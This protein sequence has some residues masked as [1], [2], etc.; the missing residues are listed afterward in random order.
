MSDDGGKERCWGFGG[1]WRSELVWVVEGVLQRSDPVLRWVSF[2][3]V[4]NARNG[5]GSAIVL[6]LTLA[7]CKID[8]LTPA[9]PEIVV[10]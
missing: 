5:N 7:G 10:S 6:L 1:L 9:S 3:V 4:A 2:D 8:R